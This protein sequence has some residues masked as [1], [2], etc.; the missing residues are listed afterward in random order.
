MFPNKEQREFRA[1]PRVVPIHGTKTVRPS[2]SSQALALLSQSA[3]TVALGA[4]LAVAVA[5]P[6]LRR[7]SLY[8][9]LAALLAGGMLTLSVQHALSHLFGLLEP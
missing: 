2:V 7:F 4:F 3:E 9:L 1:G 5:V 8:L 6:C